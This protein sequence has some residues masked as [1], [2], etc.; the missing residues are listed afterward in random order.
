[1]MVL[2]L[3]PYFHTELECDGARSV[4]ACASDE[5]LF[6]HTCAARA[7]YTDSRVDL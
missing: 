4:M 2:I 3:A 7:M 6:G 5:Y 1:M